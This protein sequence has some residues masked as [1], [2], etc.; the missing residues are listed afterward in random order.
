MTNILFFKQVFQKYKN[1]CD[2]YGLL[3]IQDHQEKFIRIYQN[4][5]AEPKN[6]EGYR[7]NKRLIVH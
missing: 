3:K 6:L 1:L 5:V 4:G 2:R 7:Y